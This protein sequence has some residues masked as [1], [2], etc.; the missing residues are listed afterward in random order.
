MYQVLWR[1]GNDYIE[2]TDAVTQKSDLFSVFSTDNFS[3]S[4]AILFHEYSHPFINPLTEKYSDIANQYQAAYEA[5]KKYKLPDFQSG[6]GDWQECINEHLVRAM[7]IHLTQ[8]CNLTELADQL[9]NNDLYRGYRYIPLILERY[10]FYDKNRTNYTDFES[11][12][13]EV[14]RVFTNDI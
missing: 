8:K 14:L 5:L 2:F 3:L 6:Y 9:R 1:N 4:P 7:T 10:E 11:F 12:Y 13:P